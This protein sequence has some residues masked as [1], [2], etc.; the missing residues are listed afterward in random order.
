MNDYDKIIR[1]P[2][3]FEAGALIPVICLFAYL[4]DSLLFSDTK[5]ATLT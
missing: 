1:K 5:A 3:G 4:L 2:K